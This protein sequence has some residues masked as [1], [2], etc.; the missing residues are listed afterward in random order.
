M[1]KTYIV[2]PGDYAASIAKAHDFFNVDDLWT[3]PDNA[4]LAQRRDPN[5]LMPGDEVVIPDLEPVSFQ[6][7]SGQSHEFVVPRTKLELRL[8][9]AAAVRG[10][11]ADWSY[12]LKV[13]ATTSNGTLD[14]EG[15]LT[16]KLPFG[17]KEGRLELQ[18]PDGAS[19]LECSL[20][21]GHLH[22][23]DEESGAML[24]LANLGY[25]RPTQSELEPLE[26]RSAIEEF[27]CDQEL[28]VDG[29]LSSAT[30]DKLREVHGC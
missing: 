22:P 20:Q 23:P 6:A 11:L 17:V 8:Q 7:S 29:E 16:A 12:T 14:G 19:A 18:A 24:R 4:E 2:E 3:H 1:S 21:I 28:T 26:L 25:L 13:G 9:V 5:F 30:V 15:K 27:Q 10:E